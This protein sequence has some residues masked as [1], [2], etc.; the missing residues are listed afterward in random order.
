[1]QCIAAPCG[2]QASAQG[3]SEQLAVGELRAD[4]ADEF[5]LEAAFD[6]EVGVEAAVESLDEPSRVEGL[7]RPGDVEALGGVLQ[8]LALQLDAAVADAQ[9]AAFHLHARRVDGERRLERC[10]PAILRI[11]AA[12]VEL[13]ARGVV[14]LLDIE[15]AVDTP[16]LRLRMQRRRVDARYARLRGPARGGTRIDRELAARRSTDQRDVEVVELHA[17]GARRQ[18]A[19]HAG[20]RN[21]ALV[22]RSGCEVAR[23]HRTDQ[24]Q[25]R[26]SDRLEVGTHR[27]VGG[28]RSGEPGTRVEPLDVDTEAAQWIGGEA[29]ELDAHRTTCPLVGSAGDTG[30]ELEG[31]QRIESA[32]HRLHRR[33]FGLAADLQT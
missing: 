26:T 4:V 28:G 18:A 23:F 15:P 1:M 25:A 11:D 19:A 31:H 24:R 12:Q 17:L 20:D 6:R 9:H 3:P 5:R 22:P 29:G 8:E 13:Q 33:G 32:P 30:I 16:R 27:E 10:R 14:A 2:P 7:H 21:R